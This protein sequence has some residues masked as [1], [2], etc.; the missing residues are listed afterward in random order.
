M[1]LA[2]DTSI[3]TLFTESMASVCAPV[4]IVSTATE[5]G[6]PYATTVSAFASL[7]L[8]PPMVSIALDRRSV[9]LSHTRS[10][11]GLGVNVLAHHQAG[12]AR[13]FA[14]SHPGK[15]ADVDWRWDQDLPRIAETTAWLVCQIIR[16]V[17]GGDHVML[18]AEVVHAETTGAPPL[19]YARR[20]FGTHSA[21]LETRED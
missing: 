17:A 10:R 13:A 21:L 6:Q 16:T 15:F 5:S 12:L 18:F 20:T 7:S 3:R 1:A 2:N 4:T 9:L 8:E 11:S 19:V 14:R